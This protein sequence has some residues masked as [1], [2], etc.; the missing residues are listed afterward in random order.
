VVVLAIISMDG[1]GGGNEINSLDRSEAGKLLE[2]ARGA[3][4]GVFAD[5]HGLVVFAAVLD[6]DIVHGDS[7]AWD[8]VGAE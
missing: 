5:G 3:T 1:N 7:A 8:L 4:L 6:I 2:A